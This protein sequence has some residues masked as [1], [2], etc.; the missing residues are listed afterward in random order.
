MAAVIDVVAVEFLAAVL[1]DLP[2]FASADVR[3][4][5]GGTG[6]GH[7]VHLSRRQR[8]PSASPCVSVL[9]T[10][11]TISWSMMPCSRTRSASVA[12]HACSSVTSPRARASSMSG[13]VS[14]QNSW[15]QAL[16]S[17]AMAALLGGRS[18]V[19]CGWAMVGLLVS[20]EDF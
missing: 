5:P 19:V 13:S 2:G 1:E 3:D 11:S 18:S 16:S 9:A 4:L 10:C 7:V 20:S 15:S 12:L 8:I 17:Q 6:A 14:C